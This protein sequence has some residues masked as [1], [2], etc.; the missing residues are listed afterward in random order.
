M[1]VPNVS[2]RTDGDITLLDFG[3]NDNVVLRV[4][5]LDRCAPSSFGPY[6]Y[7][8]HAFTCRYASSRRAI[9]GAGLTLAHTVPMFMICVA[10]PKKTSVDP[11][12]KQMAEFEREENRDWLTR[13]NHPLVGA[14]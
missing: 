4:E 8:P 11:I 3:S 13:G 6:P 12:Q 9:L 10:F 14:T 7:V 1:R 2:F 5:S